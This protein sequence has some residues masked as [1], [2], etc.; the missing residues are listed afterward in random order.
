MEHFTIVL[1]SIL[2]SLATLLFPKFGNGSISEFKKIKDP[3]ER[4]V[5][6]R[7]S[8]KDF[9]FYL[10]FFVVALEI[11]NYFELWDL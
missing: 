8:L 2:F 11:I 3:K 4:P 1:Y 6:F 5:F 10:A 7:K 9:L